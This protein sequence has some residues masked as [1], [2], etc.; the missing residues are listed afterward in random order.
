MTATMKYFDTVV[1]HYRAL[2]E[3]GYAADFCD[4]RECTDL[5]DYDLVSAPCF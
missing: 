3:Q 5:S 4:M 1:M 2:W